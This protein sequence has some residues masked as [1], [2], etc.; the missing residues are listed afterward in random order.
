MESNKNMPI[1]N[2]GTMTLKRN[3]MAVAIALLTLSCLGQKSTKVKPNKWIN[4]KIPEPSDICGDSKTENFFVVSDDGILYE[5]DQNGKMIKKI[6]E[7]DA[8]FEAVYVD[9]NK[10]YAV[11][12]RHR[13]VCIYD[14]S[15]LKKVR[16]LTVPYGGGRNRGFEALTF[17]SSKNNFILVTEKDPITLFELDSNFQ[18]TNQFDLSKIARDISAASFH[19]NAVWLLSDEDR[20][21]YKLDPFSYE[22]LSKWLLPV[23][24]PEGLAFDQ[25]G[26]LLITCDDMQRI[27]YFNN[28]EK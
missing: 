26:N 15:S 1:K 2:T 17:N 11:N 21:I 12:E 6:V 23:I 5:I 8:D 25:A 22:I 19:N 10:V 28:L 16:T 20:T 9:D 14:R 4:T 18:I 24:N 3:I 13:K 7:S 27:Y